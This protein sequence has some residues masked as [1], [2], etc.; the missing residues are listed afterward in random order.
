MDLAFSDGVC[1]QFWTETML[2]NGDGTFQ[3]AQKYSLSENSNGVTMADLNGDGRGDVVLSHLGGN[4]GVLL[5]G[6]DGKLKAETTYPLP[7]GTVNRPFAADFNRDG[8]PDIAVIDRKQPGLAVFV[9]DGA[10][11]LVFLAASALPAA[12]NWSTFADMNNDGNLDAVFIMDKDVGVVRGS[13]DG[14]FGM[15][16]TT[17]EGAGPARVL[18]TDLDTDGRMDVVVTDIPAGNIAVFLGQGDGT[19]AG[20][21]RFAVGSS[22]VWIAAD[23]LNGDGLRDLVVG[24][25]NNGQSAVAV[26]LNT[27]M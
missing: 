21:V 2:G 14:R 5:S 11:S 1:C 13:G 24:A 9:G 17:F 7:M 6:I 8:R 3:A 23:D 26:L 20:A 15:P 22:P 18:A 4:T 16:W 10:G 27:S 19:L 12:A 25:A